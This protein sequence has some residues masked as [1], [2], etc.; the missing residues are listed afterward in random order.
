LAAPK[1]RHAPTRT[2]TTLETLARK[3]IFQIPVDDLWKIASIFKCL[4]RQGRLCNTYDSFMGKIILTLCAALFVASAHAA[5]PTSTLYMTTANRFNVRILGGTSNAIVTSQQYNK[6]NGESGIAVSGG[7]IRLAAG[8]NYEGY[9]TGGTYDLNFNATGTAYPTSVGFGVFDGTTD[10][11]NNYG[12]NSFTGVVYR[13]DLNWGSPRP[14][15]TLPLLTPPGRPIGITYAQY[16]SSLWISYYTN[17][18][19]Q[20]YTLDGRLLSSFESGYTKV[21]L[22]A[23][24]PADQTLWLMGGNNTAGVIDQFS[25]AGVHLQQVSFG[26]G[27]TYVGGEF[28]INS[29]Y[30]R[31]TLTVSMSNSNLVLSWPTNSLTPGLFQNSDLSTTNWTSVTNKA[32][33]M[34]GQAQVVISGPLVGNCFFRLQSQ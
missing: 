10:G 1:I 14:L 19:V 2:G 18:I 31:A 21:S 8:S 20:D 12:V 33:V 3:N 23:F 27:L 30:T 16:N 28:E 17:G 34:N 15:F 7:S 9:T 5:G 13:Y 32:I 6:T 25:T 22:L 29:V 11:L 24:D 4:D 26:A